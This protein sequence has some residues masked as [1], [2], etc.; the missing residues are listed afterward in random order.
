MKRIVFINNKGGVGKTTLTYHL[1]WMWALQGK[2]VL[3]AD[4]D[5]QSNLTAMLLG[6]DELANLWPED[7]NEHLSI[8]GAIRPLDSGLGDIKD[9]N[10]VEIPDSTGNLFLLPGDLALST[11]EDKFS[12][13]WL[14]ALD[15]DER[16]WRVLTSFQR[17]VEKA[18][19]KLNVD[20]ILLDVG[21]NLGAINRA[22]L[23]ASDFIVVP[24]ATDLFSLQG[25]RNLGP[26]LRKWQKDWQTRIA[27]LN[28][29]DLSN[30]IE[31]LNPGKMR[32][33]GYVVQQH[34]T[35]KDRVVKAFN[36]WA[37]RLPSV[38]SRFMLDTAIDPE[39]IDYQN[40]RYCLGFVKNYMSLLPMAMEANKPIFLL[41]PA[42]GAI[43]SHLQNVHSA[44]KAFDELA[45]R[46]WDACEA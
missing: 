42:D 39:E 36:Q 28:E 20:I 21:P 13:A 26:T 31:N 8:Y 18:A 19:L 40:D 4:L 46:I 33:I 9:I 41:K 37:V 17:I 15:S 5:P 45:N 11:L 6:E 24:V 35:R 10:P 2:R 23:I 12:D 1:A 44:Y 22:G 29:G 32:P 34:S 43:G 38:F 25:L 7:L 16:E 27:K 3:V 14:K 30:K